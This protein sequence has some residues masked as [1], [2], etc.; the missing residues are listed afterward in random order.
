MKKIITFPLGMRAS[1]SSKNVLSKA[2]N[3]TSMSKYT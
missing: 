1:K 2:M 3:D